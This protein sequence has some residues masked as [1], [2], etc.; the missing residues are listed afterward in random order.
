[1]VQIA[2]LG[3]A[4]FVCY[5]VLCAVV[6]LRTG[7]TGGLVHVAQAVQAFGQVLRR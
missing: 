3:S 6:V 5:L 2:L 7:T 1:M 4:C